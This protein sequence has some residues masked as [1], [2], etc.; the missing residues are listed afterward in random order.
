MLAVKRLYGWSY[1]AT[2]RFVA[3]SLVLRPFC[4]VYPAPVPE[5][6]TLPCWA[7]LIEP[8]T[9]S[10]LNERM[11]TLAR[12]LKVTGSASPAWIASF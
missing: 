7:S 1:Q 9:L 10:A 3:D 4:R 6:T 2:E 12:S 5:D 8:A 11:V